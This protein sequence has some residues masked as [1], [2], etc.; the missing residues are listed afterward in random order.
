ME[1]YADLSAAFDELN[2]MISLISLLSLIYLGFTM[3]PLMEFTLQIRVRSF[4]LSLNYLSKSKTR[5]YTL[6][7]MVSLSWPRAP[8]GTHDHSVSCN[9]TIIV[10]VVMGHPL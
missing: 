6:R 2:A 9:Q 3:L 4:S 7:L 1:I 5:L 8:C 10:L